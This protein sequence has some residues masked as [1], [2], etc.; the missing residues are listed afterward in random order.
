MSSALATDNARF[1]IACAL[2]ASLV[3]SINDIAVRSFSSTLPLHEVV[4]VRSIV[5]LAF[6]MLVL[7]PRGMWLGMFRTKNLRL[8]L[9]RGMFVVT[10]NFAF[11][12]G[13]AVLP[14]AD[15]SAI[16][17]VAPLVITG[18]SAI[19][20][21]EAVGIRRWSALLVGLFGVMLIIRPGTTSFQWAVLLPL[22]AAVA[23]AG[24]HT[25]T[26]KIGQRDTALTMSAYIQLVFI[27]TCI[28]MGL[29][30]GS[31]WMDGSGGRVGAFIFRAWQMPTLG[32]FGI[33]AIAGA[34]S[35]FGGYLITQAYRSASAGIVAPFE[36]SALV[37]ATV[38]GF[39]FWAEVP[40]WLSIAGIVLIICSG[41]FIA[42][43]EARQDL[44]AS[45]RR[46]AGRR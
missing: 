23:Y 29:V 26:R 12:A 14:M 10:S 5:G 22:C 11:F 30:F 37:L 13:L 32:E 2:G 24:L 21:R 35:A 4:F 28:G 19:F 45:A 6:I 20:L 16:F 7:S 3:F 1:A 46:A 38:W 34:C 42:L 17:F 41:V 44:P 43:R 15:A 25:L 33:M 9:V 8:Q 40:G 18:F 36:Y 39:A 31:G 27:I